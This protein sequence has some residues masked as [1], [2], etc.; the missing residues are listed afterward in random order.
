MPWI[1]DAYGMELGP[2]LANGCRP[3]SGDIIGS[4][5][6]ECRALNGLMCNFTLGVVIN[7]TID[8]V[9]FGFGDVSSGFSVARCIL[10][11]SK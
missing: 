6:T 2:G 4:N 8:G 5:K 7:Q 9:Q 1:A 11:R 3:A 10:T